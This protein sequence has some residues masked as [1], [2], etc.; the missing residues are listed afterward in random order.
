M[1]DDWEYQAF[2]VHS[3]D[4]PS[5]PNGMKGAAEGVTLAPNDAVFSQLF[6]NIRRHFVDEGMYMNR[7]YSAPVCTPSR[8]QF[9][10]G[11]SVWSQSNGDW[12]PPRARYSMLSEK[13]KQAGYVNHLVGK[14]CAR[15]ELERR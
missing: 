2:P 14:W 9:M 13:L 3:S 11:R 12:H 4:T 10:T 15:L 1:L 5:G 6:P 8:K 7:H